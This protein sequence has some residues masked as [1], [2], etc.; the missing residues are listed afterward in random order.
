MHRGTAPW[1][2]REWTTSTHPGGRLQGSRP[3]PPRL[4][5]FLP[6]GLKE[7]ECL[8][9]SAPICGVAARADDIPQAPTT[10]TGGNPQARAEHLTQPQ[11]PSPQVSVWGSASSCLHPFPLPGTPQ[12]PFL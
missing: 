9:V 4:S 7:R 3:C 12:G 6:P 8:W 10:G 5:A 1:G 2:H 11:P